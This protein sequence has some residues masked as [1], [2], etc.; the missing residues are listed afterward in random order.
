MFSFS[1]WLRRWCEERRLL[2]EKRACEER[3]LLKETRAREAARRIQREKRDHQQAQDLLL[4]LHKLQRTMDPLMASQ[5]YNNRFCPLTRLPGELLLHI[6]DFLDDV[7]ALHILQIVSRRFRFLLHHEKRIW[8]NAWCAVPL[9]TRS[10]PTL[11]S[12]G[13]LDDQKQ[14]RRLLQRDGRCDNCKRWNDRYGLQLFDDCKFQ[15]RNR[16]FD[17]TAWHLS[18]NRMGAYDSFYCNPCNSHHAVCQ[19]SYANL[20]P[21]SHIGQRRCLGQQGSVQLC[22]HVQ[23]T[24]ASIKAHI[25]DWRRQ[26]QQRS[27]GDWQACLDSFNIECD[28]ASHDTRCTSS[29]AP[30]WPRAR[31][32]QKGPSKNVSLVLE[33]TPHSRV[34]AL[35]LTTDGRI[36]ASELRALFQSLRRRGPADTLC[37]T[38]RPGA[39]PELVCFSPSSALGPFVYYETGEDDQKPPPPLASFPPISWR[40]KDLSDHYWLCQNGFEVKIRP[41]YLTGAGITGISSQC[42]VIS[43]MKIIKVCETRALVDHAIKIVPT[44]HWLHAMDTRTY[45]HP[46]TPEIRPQCRN[47]TCTNYHRRL[48]ETYLCD[49]WP[50]T[51]NPSNEP[52]GV[53]CR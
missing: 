9:A 30:T 23:I 25:D 11:F 51:T 42:L 35:T 5:V 6:V 26:E 24:W 31:L 48:K 47:K 37:P 38:G 39:L 32:R 28:H 21:L 14:F 40:Y 19:F 18:I 10:R 27:G 34:D 52:C 36:P 50:R 13:R 45:P 3:R 2:Q 20:K 41:H 43:Y 4:T 7:V 29:E 1:R 33:W 44:E 53:T 46:H 12:L 17:R 15:P 8:K 16:T 49:T 22:E